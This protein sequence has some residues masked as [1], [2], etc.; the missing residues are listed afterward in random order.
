MSRLHSCNTFNSKNVQNSLFYCKTLSF[1]SVKFSKIS[2][3]AGDRREGAKREGGRT[4]RRRAEERVF[5]ER[6]GQ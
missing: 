4:D 6:P 2:M 3:F 1:V 5:Q